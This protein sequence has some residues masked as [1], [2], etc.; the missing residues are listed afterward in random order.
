MVAHVAFI[1]SDKN[2][3]AAAVTIVITATEIPYA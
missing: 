1:C 3:A 2:N